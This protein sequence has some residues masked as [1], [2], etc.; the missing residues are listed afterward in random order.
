MA[1]FT[2]P[3]T[4]PAGVRALRW[5]A[6]TAVAWDKDCESIVQVVAHKTGPGPDRYIERLIDAD[7]YS[8]RHC[9]IVPLTP[10]CRDLIAALAAS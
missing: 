3:T 5:H 9:A 7:G 2:I 4:V 10:F 8:G 1:K 6:G